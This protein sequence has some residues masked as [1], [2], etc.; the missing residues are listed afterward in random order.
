M[1]DVREV[2]PEDDF[3]RLRLSAA[4]ARHVPESGEGPLTVWQFPAGASNLTYLLARGAWRGVLRRPPRGPVAAKAHDM[5]R[6]YHWLARLCGAFPLAP[7][8]YWLCDDPSVLPV[9]FYVMEYRPGDVID[10]ALPVDLPPGIPWGERVSR[11]F[12]ATLCTLHA[13]DWQVAGLGEFGHP[14]GFLARQVER[15]IERYRRAA[16]DEIPALEPLIDWLTRSVPP[17]PPPTA[18]HNDFKLNNLIVAPGAPDEVRAVVDWEMATIGDPLLDL[19]VALSYWVEPSDSPEL[20][21]GLPYPSAQPGFWT[22]T[23]IAQ[24]YARRSGLAI[25][26]LP[27][28]LVFAYFK[29]AVIVQQIFVRWK[30]GQTTD[31][32]FATFDRRVRLLIERAAELAGREELG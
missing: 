29:L 18:I 32:R 7:R 15:W 3:D 16:T 9:P 2:R 14:E 26:A 24:E 23:E 6:E 22:R 5:D 31:P 28:Y 25:D 20:R 8:P 19:G 11:S 21:E 13:V 30:R 10:R 1:A 12:V 4:L 17:S 27:Y